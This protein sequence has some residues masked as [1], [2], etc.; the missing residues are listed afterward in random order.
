MLG[1]IDNMLDLARGV[2]AA[3][4]LNRDSKESLEPCCGRS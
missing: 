1:L 4:D 2:W 3:V